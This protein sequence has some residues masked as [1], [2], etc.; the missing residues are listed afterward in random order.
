MTAGRGL[1]A[2]STVLRLTI[3]GRPSTPSRRVEHVAQRTQ[4]DPERVGVE[5]A[6]AARCPGRRRRPSSGVWAIS[7]ST[8]PPSA[9]RRARCPPLRS[10]AVRSATSIRNG[11]PLGGEPREDPR[12][13]HRAEVVGVRDEG[14]AVAALEQRVEHARGHRARCRGRRGRAAPTPGRVGRPLRRREVVGAQLGHLVLHE[15]ERQRRPRGRRSAPAPRASR[16]ASRSCSSAR[17]AAA[18]RCARAG[19][20]TGG[21][22]VEERAARP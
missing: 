7:R 11:T 1:S 14:V 13:E 20:R 18:R 4:V 22:E 3:I 9:R 21:D 15:V 16:R 8:S 19:R 6:V 12:V 5:E 17:A 10:A 2:G